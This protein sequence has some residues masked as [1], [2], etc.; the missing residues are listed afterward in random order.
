M[1]L[2]ERFLRLALWC[3]N[4]EL[5]ARRGGKTPGVQPWN[6]ELV[7]ALKLELAVS[8]SRQDDVVGVQL[9]KHEE[10]IGCRDAA[11]ILGWTT[12]QVQR[13]A[14]GLEGRKTS[15]GWIFPASVVE[16][17]AKGLTNDRLAS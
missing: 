1:T 14:S 8:G 3:A 4:Q 13:R 6:A 2:D 11:T 17:Y 10:W 12:R 15:A 7:R 9:S 16:E 5:T